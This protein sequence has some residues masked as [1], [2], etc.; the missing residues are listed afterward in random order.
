MR[1]EG[2]R[3]TFAMPTVKPV[4]AEKGEAVS[5]KPTLGVERILSEGD[6]MMQVR[7]AK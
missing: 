2:S 1:I 3:E 4:S 6:K 7:E 5:V